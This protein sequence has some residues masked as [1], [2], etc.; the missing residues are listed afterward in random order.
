MNCSVASSAR[1]RFDPGQNAVAPFPQIK[2]A[3]GRVPV[4]VLCF[5]AQ[6]A[7]FKL[8]HEFVRLLSLHGARYVTVADHKQRTLPDNHKLLLVITC[9]RFVSRNNPSFWR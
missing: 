6:R 7:G 5:V 8:L 4:K 9:S 2:A 3:L 1:S